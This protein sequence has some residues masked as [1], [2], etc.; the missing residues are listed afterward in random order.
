KPV[1]PVG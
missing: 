1:E